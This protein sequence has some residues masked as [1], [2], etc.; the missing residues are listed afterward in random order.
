MS[1]DLSKLPWLMRHSRRSLR[2]IRQNIGLSL[3]TKAAFVLLTFL[4]YASLWS[5]IAADMGVSLI[6]IF[7]ALTLLADSGQEHRTGNE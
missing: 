5:A 4:G 3:L 6:V 2:I 1:D 7:N